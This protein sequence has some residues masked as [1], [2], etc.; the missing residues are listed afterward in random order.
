MIIIK[1]MGEERGVGMGG[2]G[3]GRGGEGERGKEKEEREG[4]EVR[5]GDMGGEERECGVYE[6]AIYLRDPVV[7]IINTY[8]WDLGWRDRHGFRYRYKNR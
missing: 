4:W 3:R 8:I 5:R 6:K 7:I 2:E 1:G